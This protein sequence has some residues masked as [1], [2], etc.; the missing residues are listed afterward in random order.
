MGGGREKPF[1][2]LP[3]QGLEVDI[4]KESRSVVVVEVLAQL[5]H[6]TE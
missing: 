2:S 4:A 5:I 3:S 1:T 6:F